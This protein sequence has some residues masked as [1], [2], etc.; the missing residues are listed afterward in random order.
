[1]T[2]GRRPGGMSAVL[3]LVAWACAPG[4][5]GTPV[6]A[7]RRPCVPANGIAQSTQPAV[8]QRTTATEPVYEPGNPAACLTG[9]NVLVLVGDT[10]DSVHPGYRVIRDGQFT[11]KGNDAQNLLTI[12]V[13]THGGPAGAAVEYRFVELSAMHLDHGLVIDDYPRAERASFESHRRPGLAVAGSHVCNKSTGGFRIHDILWVGSHV[14]RLTVTFTQQCVGSAEVFQGCLHYD[15][16]QS[17]R[18][19]HASLQRQERSPP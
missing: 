13:H 18:S 10:R 11:E 12:G 19:D 14:A 6:T 15:N 3:T 2:N 1:M 5:T 4:N 17:P 16:P 7:P 8:D 9:G